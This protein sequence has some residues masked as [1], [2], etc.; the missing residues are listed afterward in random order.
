MHADLEGMTQAKWSALSYS[1]REAIRDY[2]GLSPQLKGLEGYRV[3]V[4]R[5]G[6]TRPRRFIVGMSTGWRP[7]HL[8]IL[9][10]RSHGG[11]PADK[12]Y[13]VVTKFYKVR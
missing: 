3:E 8:E 9:T 7:C 12:Q 5:L 10:K 13:R 1:Q 2:S 4:I 11:S 6:D